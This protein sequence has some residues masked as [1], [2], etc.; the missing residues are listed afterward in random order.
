MMNEECRDIL[1]GVV[2]ESQKKHHDYDD[3][4][5]R[6]AKEEEEKR[7]HSF[8]AIWSV[9]EFIFCLME[10]VRDRENI[11]G[12]MKYG[13]GV[14]LSAAFLLKVLDQANLASFFCIGKRIH[15]YKITGSLT[16]EDDTINRFL[17]VSKYEL[18]VIDW[19]YVYSQLLLKNTI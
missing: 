7:N 8:A 17:M 18:S 12:F 3:D 11:D 13:H 10:T 14:L 4:D 15:R 1:N 19:A 5:E 16:M 6:L 9:L 2:D